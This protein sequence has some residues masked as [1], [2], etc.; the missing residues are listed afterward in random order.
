MKVLDA[1]PDNPFVSIAIASE[2]DRLCDLVDALRESLIESGLTSYEDVADLFDCD[3]WSEASARFRNVLDDQEADE[4]GLVRLFFSEYADRCRALDFNIFGN[5]DPEL[6]EE[7]IRRAHTAEQFSNT[8]VGH[9]R[10]N[11]KTKRSYEADS[12]LATAPFYGLLYESVWPLTS[13]EGLGDHLRDILTYDDPLLLSAIIERLAD[14]GISIGADFLEFVILNDTSLL[15]IRH[16]TSAVRADLFS[17]IFSHFELAAFGLDEGTYIS[18]SGLQYSKVGE[19]VDFRIAAERLKTFFI[20]WD[21][22]KFISMVD[23]KEVGVKLRLTRRAT[24]TLVQGLPFAVHRAVVDCLDDEQRAMRA[25][26]LAV[27]LGFDNLPLSPRSLP[28]GRIMAYAP[29]DRF[30]SPEAVFYVLS[31]WVEDRQNRKNRI[32]ADRVITPRVWKQIVLD[33]LVVRAAAESDATFQTCG[34]LDTGVLATAL[35]HKLPDKPT[36]PFFIDIIDR[37]L[38]AQI[39]PWL[40]SLGKGIFVDS[41]HISISTMQGSDAKKRALLKRW[42]LQHN[43]VFERDGRLLLAKLQ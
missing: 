12:R 26:D 25:G 9:F 17:E 8:F 24:S 23:W 5:L 40:H 37:M 33:P 11:W 35:A 41:R 6:L 28:P 7:G 1:G 16:E 30:M 13:Y 36:E 18:S 22:V 27:A 42:L 43:T 14:R 29:C 21:E 10:A 15:T 32:P 39:S 4:A 3:N 31:E 20:W 2:T 38:E 19:P 34:I